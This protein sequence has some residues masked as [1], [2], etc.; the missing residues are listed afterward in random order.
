MMR[1]LSRG[2]STTTPEVLAVSTPWNTLRVN[3]DSNQLP[4]TD[5]MIMMTMI[6]GNYFELAS[7]SLPNLLVAAKG[8]IAPERWARP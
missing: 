6:C 1:I 3:N 2:V 7:S 8:E 4:G 5:T